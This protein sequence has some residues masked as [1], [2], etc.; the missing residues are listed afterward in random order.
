MRRFSVLVSVFVV[1]LGVLI[2][3][4]S[5][6][7]TGA[8]EGTPPADDY[9]QPEGVMFEGLAFGLAEALPAGPT[10]LG[11]F[12]TTLEPGARIDLE[13]HPSYFLVSVQSGAV[14]YRVETP[15]LVTRAVTGTPGAQTLGPDAPAEEISPGTDFTLEAGDAAL[16]PPST[17]APDEG[18]NDGQES[19]VLLVVSVGP[20][21]AE[22]EATPGVGT[23]PAAA[24]AAAESTPV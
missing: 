9:E 18:R 11:L 7:T 24:E 17:G 13:A 5:I 22:D 16:F 10:G 21:E 15:V 2:A 14:T 12:R 4:G 23:P 6:V 8:Q 19:A 1:L 20:A 3:V